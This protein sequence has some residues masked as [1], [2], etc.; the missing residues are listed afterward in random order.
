M[1][2]N[3]LKHAQ[4]FW[5]KIDTTVDMSFIKIVLE[6]YTRKEKFNFWKQHKLETSNPW[7]MIDYL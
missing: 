2:R 7:H 1:R 5:Q 3:I 6:I 4:V